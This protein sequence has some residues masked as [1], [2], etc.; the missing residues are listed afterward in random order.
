MRMA[1]RGV[2]AKCAG[3]RMVYTGRQ[4][5]SGNVREPLLLFPLSPVVPVFSGLDFPVGVPASFENRQG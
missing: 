2:H 4:S 5:G 1:A 3:H